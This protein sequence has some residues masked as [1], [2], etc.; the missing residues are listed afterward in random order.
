MGLQTSGMLPEL[1]LSSALVCQCLCDDIMP[2][3]APHVARPG[4]PLWF[5]SQ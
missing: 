2:T 3:G 1:G 4:P 5:C